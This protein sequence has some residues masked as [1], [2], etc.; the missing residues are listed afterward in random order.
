M[1]D[2]TTQKPTI[3]IDLGT[4]NTCLAIWEKGKAVVLKNKAGKSTTP[5][6]VSFTPN[7]YF[8]GDSA[9]Y[10]SVAHPQ[11]TIFDAKRLIGRSHGTAKKLAK[12]WPFN[13]VN[14]GQNI[15][16]YE[17][18]YQNEKKNIYPEQI[19]AIVLKKVKDEA[20][21]QLGERIENVVIT[22]PAYFNENQ[23]ESTKIAAEIAGLNVLKIITEPA[24]AVLAFG[25]TIKVI[26][27]R[28]VLVY[29]IGIYL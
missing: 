24:A 11:N 10:Q 25:S 16:Q 8:V 22:V 13:L 28:N 20:E 3:G 14:D 7:G 17:V 26:A 1:T 21:S 5:S 23:R 2:T 15:P 12:Y 18:E 27:E 9:I 19:S 4:T 6:C 29:D